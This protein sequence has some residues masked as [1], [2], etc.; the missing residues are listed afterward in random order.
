MGTGSG[1]VP[2]KTV[3]A[4]AFMPGRRSDSLKI[5]GLPALGRSWA[6]TPGRLGGEEHTENGREG[7]QDHGTFLLPGR[8]SDSI[9]VQIA[10]EAEGCGDGGSVFWFW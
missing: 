3:Q 1:S 6:A 8:T 9:I 7:A 5:S 4:V 2:E 10:R